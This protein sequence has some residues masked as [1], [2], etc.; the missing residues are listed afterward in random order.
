MALVN[1]G[2]IT[3]LD[4]IAKNLELA[5]E[6][7]GDVRRYVAGRRMKQATVHRSVDE[8]LKS[9]YKTITM[10]GDIMYYRKK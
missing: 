1:D 7:Y 5:H 10:H 8:E 9:K 3:S 6:I 4:I 2:A